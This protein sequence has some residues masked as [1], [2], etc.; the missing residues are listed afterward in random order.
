[1]KNSLGK[2]EWALFDQNGF[3]H[4]LKSWRPQVNRIKVYLENQ[5]YLNG[6]W[7]DLPLSNIQ[8][9][10]PFVKHYMGCQFCSGINSKDAETCEKDFNQSWDFA[11][12]RM[13]QALFNSVK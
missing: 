11:N 7:K 1:M 13:K 4:V 10:N 8:E 2:Y 3:A 6:Y 9:S 5:Y 12:T